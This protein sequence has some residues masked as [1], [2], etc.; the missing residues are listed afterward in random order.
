MGYINGANLYEYVEANPINFIDSSGLAGEKITDAGTNQ[1]EIPIDDGAG[2]RG[3]VSVNSGVTV[4]YQVKPDP[5]TT[6]S[7]SS[8]LAMSYKG[9]KCDDCT[10]VQFF[11]QELLISRGINNRVAK[12]G[13]T[14][15]TAGDVTLTTDPAKPV[16]HVDGTPGYDGMSMSG[17]SE[18]TIFDQ[19]DFNIPKSPLLTDDIKKGGI[20]FIR[21]VTHFQSFL[22]CGGKTVAG[23]EWSQSNSWNPKDGPFGWRVD[24]PKGQKGDLRPN[25]SQT[26]LVHEKFPKQDVMKID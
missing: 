20:T 1:L 3:E 15:S 17:K 14:K 2:H 16:W 10:W 7:R 8:L 24:V 25:D 26:R 23:F 11:W 6:A 5:L 13:V 18:N 4:E 21:N 22:I 9:E 12:E 19:P